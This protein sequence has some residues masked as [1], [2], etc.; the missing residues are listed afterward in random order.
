MHNLVGGTRQTTFTTE[1]D[2]RKKAVAHRPCRDRMEKTAVKERANKDF[3]GGV[4]GHM[5]QYDDKFQLL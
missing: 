5:R 2:P 4:G 3:C 1:A